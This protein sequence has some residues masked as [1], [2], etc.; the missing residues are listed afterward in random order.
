VPQRVSK[1]RK[2]TAPNGAVEKTIGLDGDKKSKS[3]DA[4]LISPPKLADIGVTKTQSSRWQKSDR[5]RDRDQDAGGTP[6]RRAVAGDGGDEG[7]GHRKGRQSWQSAQASTVA[8]N[9]RA[10]TLRYR[11]HQKP[12]LTLA[13]TGR[14]NHRPRRQGPQAASQR[15]MGNMQAR[16]TDSHRSPFRRSQTDF[17]EPDRDQRLSSMVFPITS[18][19]LRPR[20]WNERPKEML[21]SS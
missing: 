6:G 20:V 11:R 14:Q 18:R 21:I 3:R 2:A 15:P 19:V 9:D 17:R 12:I 5:L 13:K 10:K 16:V 8:T 7:T 1:A 4:T